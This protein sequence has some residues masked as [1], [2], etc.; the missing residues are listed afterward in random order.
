M[1]LERSTLGKLRMRT[2]ETPDLIAALLAPGQLEVNLLAPLS[3][4]L[5]GFSRLRHHAFD[6]DKL[7]PYRYRVVQGGS[8]G[9]LD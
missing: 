5:P 8:V 3:S 9:L 7:I 1:P 2:L 4:F 6:S